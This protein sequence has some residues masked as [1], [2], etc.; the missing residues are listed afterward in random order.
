MAR[1]TTWSPR[2]RA[3][4]ENLF[5]DIINVLSALDRERAAICVNTVVHRSNYEDVPRI[6]RII[7]AYP[8]IRK[9]QLFQFSPNGPLG[10]R[11]RDVFAVTD[12]QFEETRRGVESACAREK[13]EGTVEFKSN[14]DRHSS[15]LLVDSEGIA[16][17]HDLASSSALRTVVG[18]IRRS[19]DHP[20]IVSLALEPARALSATSARPV[21]TK[22]D[23][24]V[25]YIDVAKLSELPPPAPGTRHL[26]FIGGEKE[27]RCFSVPFSLPRNVFMEAHPELLDEAL[28]PIYASDAITVRQDASYALAGFYIV[29][30]RA[31]VASLDRLPVELHLRMSL[32]LYEVRA[33]MR[34][35]LGIDL[36]HLHYEERPQASCSVHYWLM[37]LLPERCGRPFVIT[38]L[39]V[40]AYV[41]QF[42]F[43][44]SR[45]TIYEYNG[46]M[47]EHMRSIGLYEREQALA[48]ARTAPVRR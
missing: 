41:S 48:E 25:Q 8:S 15:Y 9:W 39:N 23:A 34:S 26:D 27:L 47:R 30:L 28:Q 36:V 29:A 2:F 11:N 40:L 7:R 46:R 19:H 5:A 45:D 12:E 3:G 13:F 16:Y 32:V 21:I 22:E 6:A 42:P 17:L 44:E 37:P 38:H 31:A 43:S 24:H 1:R 18:D 35:V 20:R 4:R 33:A 10:Y 14:R